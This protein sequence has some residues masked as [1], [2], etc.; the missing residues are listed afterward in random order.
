MRSG[1]LLHVVECDGIDAAPPPEVRRFLRFD[2]EDGWYVPAYKVASIGRTPEG[3]EPLF[4]PLT[5][6]VAYGTRSRAVCANRCG[7]RCPNLSCTCGFYAVESEQAARS[8]LVGR[9]GAVLLEVALTGRVAIFEW[10]GGGTMFRA[11]GQVV[12]AYAEPER[13]RGAAARVALTGLVGPGGD[14]GQAGVGARRRLVP[15]AP[16]DG[17]EWKPVPTPDVP[18]ETI[19]GGGVTAPHTDG[20]PLRRSDGQPVDSS[21]SI[22]LAKSRT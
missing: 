17:E 1:Q 8:L 18:I 13:V 11:E 21:S 20:T 2:A 12:I 19:A 3:V 4:R 22:R 7:A 10:S 14:D 9:H 5:S 16:R 15:V 6:R